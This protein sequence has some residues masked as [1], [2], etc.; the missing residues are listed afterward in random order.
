MGPRS[1][2]LVSSL[3]ETGTQRAVHRGKMMG[4]VGHLLA[5]AWGRFSS[6]AP[7]GLALSKVLILASQHLGHPFLVLLKIFFFF[8]FFGRGRFF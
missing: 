7:A 5:K 1:V 8:F 6:S 3:W 4:G 2:S